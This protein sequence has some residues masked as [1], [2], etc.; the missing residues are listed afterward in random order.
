MPATHTI[1]LPSRAAAVGGWLLHCRGFAEVT[2][3]ISQPSME[4]KGCPH[5][6]HTGMQT[7]VAQ[8]G[9]GYGERAMMNPATI[10]SSR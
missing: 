1:T 4:V 10:A 2:D 8:L 9:L 5:D 6:D 3:Q 7:A